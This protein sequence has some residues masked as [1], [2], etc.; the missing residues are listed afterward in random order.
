MRILIA[1]WPRRLFLALGILVLS[2]GLMLAWMVHA[3]Q[4][5]A[6]IYS[7]EELMKRLVIMPAL[8]AFAVFSLSTA[9]MQRSAL[10]AT[11]KAEAAPAA[12]EPAKPFMAQVV[13]L[14]WLNPLQRRDYPTEWQ[15]LWTLG[16]VKPNKNDDMVRTDPKKFTTLQPVAGIAFG[17]WGKET[18]RGYYRKYVDELLVLLRQRYLM[19]PSYFYTVASKDR[20]DWRELA[21]VHVELAV[22]AKRLDPVETQTY[23]QKEMVSFFE[24]GNR[25]A[26][27]LWSRDTPPDVRITQ[28]GANAG[29]TSLNAAL[30]YLQAH[31]Q[32][33]V[34]VM[35]WDAP[36]FPPNDEQLNENLA[37]LF[38]A[39]PDL[40]TERDPLAWIGRAATGNI[41]DHERKAGTTRVIQAWKATIE[42]A[43]KN[44]GHGIENIHY[45]IHD[46]GKGSDAASERLAGLSRTLTET[47][48]EFD[49]Q[50]QTFNTAGLLGDMGAGSALTNMALAIARANHLGG[51]VL[52]AGTTDP[53]HPTAVVVAPPSKL[54][55]ID[56]DKD[57]FRARGENNAYLPWWGHRHGESYGTLQGYSW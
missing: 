45:T 22:P 16:L 32:E 19:N 8:L 10:A 39:G 6:R 54:T 5:S 15:L 9:F 30:D 2:A 37:V 28:G 13:G 12:V 14:E 34:W 38:L 53:E 41:N 42:A 25:S 56:P 17:N 29:F 52:V 24:I 23:L 47:M 33:S 36:S 51:S 35:N 18:I 46:A 7:D 50:K 11:P 27:D 21:G 1:T 4:T 43:A 20:K 44:A 48:L 26:P 49:Y 55:P 31:P 57:W 3:E 40:K